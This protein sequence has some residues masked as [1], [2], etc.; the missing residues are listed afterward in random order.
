M[1]VKGRVLAFIGLM[2]SKSKP[3]G[4]VLPDDLLFPNDEKEGKSD[5]YGSYTY[6]TH[7]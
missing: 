1:L 6:A 2:K 3:V 7:L 4:L 5:G